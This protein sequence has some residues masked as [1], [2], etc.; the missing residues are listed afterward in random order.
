MVHIDLLPVV[1]IVSAL[2]FGG[3]AAFVY[4]TESAKKAASCVE[5]T[6][7]LECKRLP[8]SHAFPSLRSDKD[9]ELRARGVTLTSSGM[10]IKL[11]KA[12]PTRGR[13]TRS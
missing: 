6:R 2:F 7:I 10:A 11:D 9:A 5:L 3:I 12:A 1:I 8:S 4:V 13:F